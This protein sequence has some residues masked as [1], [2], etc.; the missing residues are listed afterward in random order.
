MLLSAVSVSAKEPAEETEGSEHRFEIIPMVGYQSGSTVKIQG[1]ELN[2]GASQNVGLFVDLNVWTGAQLELSWTRQDTK[3]S[4][5][6]TTGAHV[7]DLFDAAID[8]VQV[9]AQLGSLKGRA[10]MFT[11][12]GIGFTHFN[13]KGVDVSDTWKL[14]VSV[15]VGSE[16]YFAKR[17]GM[18]I[19]GRLLP[20]ILTSGTDIFCDDDRCYSKVESGAMIQWDVAAGLV[21]S[22]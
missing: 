21:V 19:H 4:L 10:F 18:R 9:G 8:Y 3:V 11:S 20:T 1:G 2:F 6:D 22:I 5:S 16:I 13:P 12:V 14:S 17:I 7:A 15:G